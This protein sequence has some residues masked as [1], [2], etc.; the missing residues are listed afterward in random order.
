MLF[1]SLVTMSSRRL[2]I[3]ARRKSIQLILTMSLPVTEQRAP[4][5]G[6]WAWKV[7]ERILVSWFTL[8]NTG[9]Y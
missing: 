1:A 6:S 2:K 9:I 5:D 7:K 8:I 4:F 3:A